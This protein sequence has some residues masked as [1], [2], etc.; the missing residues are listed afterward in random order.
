MHAPQQWRGWNHCHTHS[1]STHG[2]NRLKDVDFCFLLR[3]IK[4][5]TH[6]THSKMS[7]FFKWLHTVKHT[8]GKQH[9]TRGRPITLI[10]G[11][12]CRSAVVNE[13]RIARAGNTTKTSFPKKTPKQTCSAACQLPV[14]TNCTRQTQHRKV[15]EWNVQPD[16]YINMT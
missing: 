1:H 10:P 12:T 7:I 8:G 9:W 13:H 15:K 2:K 3:N 4:H 11:I 14:G 5:C 6:T 16:I